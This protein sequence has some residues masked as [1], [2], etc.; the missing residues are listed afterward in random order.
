MVSQTDSPCPTVCSTAKGVKKRH[1]STERSIALVRPSASR[2]PLRD[3][4][5]G[6]LLTPTQDLTST[7]SVFS[8]CVCVDGVWPLSFCVRRSRDSRLAE[9]NG[10]R[11]REC[12]Q[13]RRFY[14]SLAMAANMSESQQRE[15]QGIMAQEQQRAQ[16]QE[17][18][19]SITSVCFVRRFVSSLP[20]CRS[21]GVS[22]TTI[23]LSLSRHTH[24][25]T[26]TPTSE[27]TLRRPLVP[28]TCLSLCLSHPTAERRG[29]C[30]G[31]S[32]HRSDV[33]ADPLSILLPPHTHS[34]CLS[35]CLFSQQDKCVTSPGNRLSN[36]ESDCLKNCAKR[37]VDV[38]KMAADKLTNR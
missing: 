10:L 3:P 23:S 14:V 12:P 6:V 13:R 16:A 18:L 15:L 29:V 9:T 28:Q 21:V 2:S 32:H 36:S 1:E 35:L 34:L 37:Y 26:H 38:T 33:T 11:N 7:H 8:W 27:V 30:L 24:T 17:F 4:L 20:P 31:R 5:R 25:H 19:S 22:R